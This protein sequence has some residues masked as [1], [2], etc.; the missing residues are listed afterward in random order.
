[1]SLRDIQR[2][3]DGQAIALAAVAMLGIAI[4]VLATVQVGR[5]VHQRIHVQNI[6][7]Q[8]A[9]SV[10]ATEARTYNFFAF[11]NRAQLTHYN[12]M[13]GLQAYVSY[14]YGMSYLIGSAT[15][16]IWEAA[17]WVNGFGCCWLLG[18]RGCGCCSCGFG[19]I[20]HCAP[21]ACARARALALQVVPQLREV[22]RSLLQTAQQFDQAVTPMRLA[23]EA[24][25]RTVMPAANEAM[26]ASARRYILTGWKEQV[27]AQDDQ[28]GQSLAA[29]VVE[30]L[31][32][33]ANAVAFEAAIEPTARTLPPNVLEPAES[34]RLMG[35][36]ANATR[37]GEFVTERKAEGSLFAAAQALVPGLTI[38]GQTKLIKDGEIRERSRNTVPEITTN[39][40]ERSIASPGQFLAS[41]EEFSG[42]TV[43]LLAAAVGAPVPM[44]DNGTFVVAGPNGGSHK[45]WD[46][47]GRYNTICFGTLYRRGAARDNNYRIVQDPERRF[48]G[49][50][51]F[52][53]FA[54]NPSPQLSFGQ[55]STW[56]FLNKASAAIDR[57][58]QSGPALQ[59]RV[60]TARR[61]GIEFDGRIGSESGFIGLNGMNVIARAQ[62]YYHRPPSM[63]GQ[64]GGDSNWKE[65]PNFFNPFWRAKL[66]PVTVGL[67]N[68]PLAGL[69]GGTFGT[70]VGENLLTH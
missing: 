54:A 46:P 9:Y 38:K 13:M 68:T 34:R 57:D 35:E 44:E 28:I 33:R 6:A 55:P 62:T 16:A 47:S 48:A 18:T 67:G 12:A 37:H 65:M 64:G 30:T 40:F 50:A 41:E 3:E 53:R 49:I 51:P 27:E 29:R 42:Q 4:G 10:A 17:S 43:P 70:L 36:L 63:G 24:G 39:R 56:I 14:L 21:T 11:S 59:F 1:M 26:V 66:A 52:M 7:D 23:I 32:S 20:T 31:L 2:E 60:S 15:D 19:C 8:A 69:F 25:N 58:G 61:Q 5:A 22:A 45:E